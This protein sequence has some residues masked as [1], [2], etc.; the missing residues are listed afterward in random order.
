MGILDSAISEMER[1]FQVFSDARV[2]NIG[3]YHVKQQND[4]ITMTYRDVFDMHVLD[5][6]ISFLVLL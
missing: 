4:N 3:E 5:F 6:G 1:R 2:R